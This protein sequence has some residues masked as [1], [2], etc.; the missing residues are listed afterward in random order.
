MRKRIYKSSEERGTSSE[1]SPAE[2]AEMQRNIQDSLRS[3]QEFKHCF[4]VFKI[5]PSGK[6][7]ISGF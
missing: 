3:F 6:D 1:K 2:A 5:R 7:Y 4:A